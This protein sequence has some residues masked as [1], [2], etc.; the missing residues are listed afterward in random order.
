MFDPTDL[1][2]P[3]PEG[4]RAWRGVPGL[5][6]EHATVLN[7]DDTPTAATVTGA[8]DISVN[9]AGNVYVTEAKD[10]PVV[11]RDRRFQVSVRFD[12]DENGVW[13]ARPPEPMIPS[14]A[15]YDNSRREAAPTHTAAVVAALTATVTH[16]VTEEANALAH[17]LHAR[18]ERER[19]GDALDRARA[20]V[21]RLERDMTPHQQ[22][23]DAFE[24]K[25]PG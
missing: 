4:T 5:A 23:I 9:R 21:T 16:Y 13:V 7:P 12:Q 11:F 2:P 10:A 18:R 3:V 15:P 1:L 14:V 8:V 6:L 25:L 24:K 20:E 19:L 22:V 17:Y